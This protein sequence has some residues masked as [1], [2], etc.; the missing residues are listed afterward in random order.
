VNTKEQQQQMS[1]MHDVGQGIRPSHSTPL[2]DAGSSPGN[3]LVLSAGQGSIGS[4]DLTNSQQSDKQT[5]A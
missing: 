4:Y 3:M 2:I 5:N 1:P